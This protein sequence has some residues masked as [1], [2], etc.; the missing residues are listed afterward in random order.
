MALDKLIGLVCGVLA[1][2]CALALVVLWV[3]DSSVEIMFAPFIAASGALCC[4]FSLRGKGN[5]D[6]KI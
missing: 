5:N 6:S 3:N 4:Y 2:G 1:I